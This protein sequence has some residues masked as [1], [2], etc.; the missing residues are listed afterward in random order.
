MRTTAQ[1]D[2]LLDE[3]DDICGECP[4]PADFEGTGGECERCMVRQLANQLHAERN[5]IT[6]RDIK[7]GLLCGKVRL[8][9]EEGTTVCHIGGMGGNWFFF[10]G[11]TAE[12]EGPWE[13]ATNM[14]FGEITRDIVIALE[15]LR[16]SDPDEWWFYHSVLDNEM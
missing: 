12:E 14:D 11:T 1:I 16:V 10:G 15:G 5:P 9:L 3:I 4:R 2:K 8:T 7:R 6:V 13:Y